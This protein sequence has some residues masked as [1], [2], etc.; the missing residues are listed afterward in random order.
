MLLKSSRSPSSNRAG[1]H[2][3]LVKYVQISVAMAIAD[4]FSK[5]DYTISNKNAKILKIFETLEMLKR[6]WVISW[7]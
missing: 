3:E 4:V 7:C 5:N 6:W 2:D 1:K